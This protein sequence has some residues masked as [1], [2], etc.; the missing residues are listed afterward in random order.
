MINP[1]NDKAD[2]RRAFLNY[3]YFTLFISGARKLLSALRARYSGTLL[4]VR[5]SP[6]GDA[7]LYPRSQCDDNKE[8]VSTTVYERTR[9]R[10]RSESC[11]KK[12]KKKG[13]IHTCIYIYTARPARVC[14]REFIFDCEE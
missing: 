3:P 2:A 1:R 5:A 11:G 14:G 7:I 8:D 10:S 13:N 9:D 6:R 4:L 12:K